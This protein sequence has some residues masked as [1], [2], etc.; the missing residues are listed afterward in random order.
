MFGNRGSRIA[1]WIIGFMPTSR[2]HGIK[3][4]LLRKLGGI[5]I[6][7]RTTIFSGARFIGRS[8]RIGSDCHI[9]SGCEIRAQTAEAWITIGDWCS[10][11]PEVY[12]TTGGHDPALGD[13]HRKNGVHL[14]ITLG[15][16]VGLCVRSMV[17]PGVNMG[18][19]S[20]AS[21][22]VVVSKNI[23]PHTL[24]APA[25]LRSIKLPY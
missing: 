9:G 16:H 25:A 10:F 13:D 5:Q 18:D 19:Y 15:C 6:G 8:I 21:P 12:M 22:G 17:M 1:S 20:Q 3:R 24:V 2:W 23:P 11:G 14:P 7:D 4:F